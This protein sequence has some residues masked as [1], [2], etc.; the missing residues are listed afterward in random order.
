MDL[1]RAIRYRGFNLNS[2]QHDAATRDMKG[3]EVTRASYH[4]VVG[5][6]YDEKKALADGFDTGDVYMGKRQIALEGNVYGRNRAEAYDLVQA[7]VE[8]LTPTDAYEEN[9]SNKGFVP[10]DF[11]V[12]TLQTEALVIP[13]GDNTM[14]P[15]TTIP[16]FPSGLIHQMLLARPVA[17]PVIEWGSDVHGGQDAD[18]L[19]VP[20]Q[21]ILEA[22]QPWVLNY[23]LTV[24]EL[25]TNL[26]SG[27]AR[28]FNRGNRPAMIEFN[29][30]IPPDING[31]SP[32]SSGKF[33]YES[34]T[35][36][37]TITLPRSAAKQTIRYNTHDKVLAL[38]GNLRM[39]LLAFD[40]GQSHGSVKPGVLDG[41]YWSLTSASGKYFLPGSYIRFRDTWA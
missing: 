28:W 37:M 38:N 2:I 13:A 32:A 20:W 9:P 1:T 10:L 12:P 17:Q 15:T 36:R 29:L 24:Y 11:Y 8:R 41:W 25:P 21:A 3:C 34:R 40:A 35:T 30:V 26:K 23:D 16:M 6:G 22:R 31:A 4:G 27:S 14:P 5:I 33:R 7:L 18:A 19:S 39:D